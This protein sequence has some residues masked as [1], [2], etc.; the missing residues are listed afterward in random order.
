MDENELWEIA[1]S[2]AKPATRLSSNPS[3]SPVGIFRGPALAGVQLPGRHLLS[4][5][6]ACL[7]TELASALPGG[8]A[9][10]HELSDDDGPRAEFLVVP[11]AVDFGRRPAAVQGVRTYA[12]LVHP[13]RGK[14]PA[15]DGQRI[16]WD[17]VETHSVLLYA[18]PDRVLPGVGDLLEFGPPRLREWLQSLGWQPGSGYDS[19]LDRLTPA[20]KQY[21]RRWWSEVLGPPLAPRP[22]WPLL[23]GHT[24]AILGGWPIP[25]RE[26]E[27]PPGRLVF[28]LFAAEEPRW[29]GVLT[30]AGKLTL[31]G[32]ES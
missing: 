10:L 31:I 30:E 12:N 26:G 20:L 24:F 29:H 28:T 7:P 9:T 19:Q 15:D 8:T 13:P 6:C 4:F 16:V 25:L 27:I 17:D 11:E 3:G 14:W 23:P 32:Q 5:A 18:H 21:N 1:L 2:M 22:L